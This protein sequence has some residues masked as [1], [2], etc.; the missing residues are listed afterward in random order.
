MFA[1]TDLGGFLHVREA[2][3]VLSTHFYANSGVTV[4]QS[5]AC[6]YQQLNFK[7]DIIIV[8]YKNNNL[9]YLIVKS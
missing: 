7:H 6:M 5:L 4:K 1:D 9:V 8:E 2:V 3:R